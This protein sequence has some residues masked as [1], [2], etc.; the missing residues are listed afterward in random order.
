MKLT[1]RSILLITLLLI[2]AGIASAQVI[3]G[4]PPFGSF[5]GGPFDTLD[6]ANLNAH[7]SIPVVNKAGRGLNFVYDLGYDSSVWYPVTSGSTTSWQ[8]VQNWGWIAQTQS[9]TGSLNYT[10]TGGCYYEYCSW[11]YTNFFYDDPFG[12]PH[13]I[14]LTIGGQIQCNNVQ[15]SSP[16]LC[17]ASDGSGYTLSIAS[18]PWAVINPAGQATAP[19]QN[20]NTGAAGKTD[21]NG[22]QITVNSSGVFTD[23]LGQTVLTLGGSGTPSSPSTFTYTAPS[24]A[25]PAYTMKYTS[26]TVRTNFGCSG[27]TEY[28]PTAQNLV[29]EIDLPDQS[30]NPADKYTF[31]YEATPGYS[32]D[33]T[34]RLA[35]VTLPT[36]GTIT[37][38]YT[39]GSSGHITCA[40]GSAATLSRQTPD[41]T[42]VY[43]HSE[44]GTA[45]ATAVTDP[46]GNETDLNFQAVSLNSVWQSYETQR[47]VYQGSASSGTLL[48]TV[49]TCYNGATSPCNSTAVTLPITQK[50]TYI[51][52]PTGLESEVITKYDEETLGSTNYS[53]GLV[54]ENDEYAYGSGAPGALV[55]KTLTTYAALT[56]NIVNRPATVTVQD[57]SANVKA[58][59]TYTYDQGSVAAT[60][61]TPQHI[62]IT[63]SRGNATTISF[64]VSGSATLTKT[65]TYYDTG[66][67]NVATDVN[68]AQTTYTYGS[69]SCGNSF[70]TS[71]S[72]PLSLSRSMAW[73]CTGG[74]ETSATDENGK[75]TSASYTDS[76]F[77]RPNS[78][79]DQLSNTANIAYTGQ[80]SVEAA[81]SFG[82]STWDVLATVDGLGRAELTQTKEAP[83]SS[84]Y[85]SVETYYD[86]LGRPYKNTLPYAANAGATCSGSCYD[87]ST[88]YDALGRPLTV[89][90]SGGGTVSYSYAANDSYQTASPVPSG[91]NTKRKQLEYDALGRLT[92]V[93]EVTSLTGSGACSQTSSAT[94]YWTTYVYDVNNNPTGVTQNAQ[95]SSAQPRSFSYDDLGR[96]NSEANPES[97]TTSY[98]YDTDSTCGTSKGDLVKKVDAVGNVTCYAYDSLHRITSTTYSGSYASV[99]PSRH[100]VYDSATVNSI[101]MANAKTRLAEAYTCFSPCST[102]LTD[103]GYSYTARGETSDIYES[104]PH[105]SGYYHLTETYWANGATNQ[106]SGLSG[107]PTITYGVDGEGRTYSASASSGQ[108]PVSSTTYSTA[109][110]PKQV[111][112]GSGDS[113]SYVYDPNTNRMTQYKFTVNGSSLTGNL[114]WNANGSL[115]SLLITD[116]FNSTDTQS[117]SYSHDDLARIASANCGSVWSQTFS[118]DAFGNIQKSGTSSFQATYSYLTNRMTQIGSSYPTYDANGNVTNDFLNAY[119]WDAN[120][121]PVTANSVNLTYDALGRM[122]EQGRGSSYTE[123]VYT[124][125]GAKFALMNGSTVQKAFVPL[126]GGATAVYNS[127][128]LAYYRHS[129][130]IGSS[131]FASTPTRAMYS[132]GAYGPFGEAYAQAGTSDLSFTGMNQDTSA[133][134]YDFPAREYGVQ[135]RWP[136]PDPGGMSSMHWED[137]QTLN[138][139]AYVRNS[140]LMMT[141]PTGLDGLDYYSCSGGAGGNDCGGMLMNGGLYGPSAG[142]GGLSSLDLNTIPAQT[143]P[144][145][146]VTG[147]IVVGIADDTIVIGG[148]GDEANCTNQELAQYSWVYPPVTLLDNIGDLI[149]GGPQPQQQ[150]SVGAELVDKQYSQ[151]G[152]CTTAASDQLEKA[153]DFASDLTDKAEQANGSDPFPGGADPTCGDQ[154]RPPTNDNSANG[155]IFIFLAV[156]AKRKYDAAVRAC[157]EQYPLAQL[158]P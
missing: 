77:W 17:P 86:S 64:L 80:T 4:T 74:V 58:Q 121:R 25:N 10:I 89:T 40:D 119:A 109:S 123:I 11:A 72:E 46:Q 125:S 114:T 106:L 23:T 62:S 55:R 151:Y 85:D 12:A 27:V 149:G 148:C 21:S 120:G 96:M 36:G 68:G 30:V 99:T 94:G 50:S 150:R 97:G 65:L 71:V 136:S 38:T 105:S 130:W 79:T 145:K 35:S 117:C 144:Q 131:R 140:P 146:V 142:Y 43:S 66:N 134:V 26:Y 73:N 82:S 20:T 128:G 154:C 91:E 112:L 92:S 133:N 61:G 84:T 15:L 118:Y 137:P 98:T 155:Y 45:W 29:T 18:D 22:N 8:P 122:V 100:F 39:G 129:D 63:G 16:Y 88:T 103:I 67:V 115:A 102:K 13:P 34:G 126:T 113:D 51:Q 57:G 59:T 95:S 158:H 14:P 33:V 132:D 116:P 48:K 108:N 83:G 3:T 87:T 104:T 127:S 93:C 2:P 7:F 54:T 42:W 90:D 81:M 110:L 124:P 19:P 78:A 152:A 147:W 32:G 141:D 143:S 41:G 101:V 24:G 56:N 47:K 37:Y 138:R 1:L 111:T 70:V 135:G 76:Y 52:W 31:T 139:Y 157:G 60:S 5:G 53:Y 28:G 6:L 156:R 44:S 9:A 69:G 107:L 153:T 75:T 49:N